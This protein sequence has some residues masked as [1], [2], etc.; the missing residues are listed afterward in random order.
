VHAGIF[1][2][3][4]R[5]YD[6]REDVRLTVRVPGA[7]SDSVK[8]LQAGRADIAILDIHDLGL[9]RQKGADLVGIAAVVQRPLA[10]V[11]AR[12]GIRSPRRL[13]RRRVGVTG[14]PSDEAV[15]SSVVRGAGGR[16]RRVRRVTI[17]FNAVRSL[18]SGRVD[19]ATG[20]WNAEGVA[21][22]RERRG[23]GFQIFR[24]DRYGAPAYPELVIAAKR[25]VLR[26]KRAVL[27]DTLR[28]LRKGYEAVRQDPAQGIAALVASNKGVE[29]GL[30]R[31]QL[32]EVGSALFAKSGRWGAFDRR[33]LRAWARW[34]VRFGILRRAPD[35]RRAFDTGLL[36]D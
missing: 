30:V 1:T 15:L 12:P 27:R 34:D 2:A 23:R 4:T 31:D 32:R 20:F 36:A 6:L 7:S 10:A 33:R 29:P 3:V 5:S 25:S 28:A 13:E 11:I 8:L 21:L 19:A 35:V 18:L 17:G 9:A 24:V 16:P 14:L 22:R 26:Q